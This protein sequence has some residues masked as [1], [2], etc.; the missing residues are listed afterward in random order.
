MYNTLNADQ[1]S[2][3]LFAA[4]AKD[5][6]CNFTHLELLK[7]KQNVPSTVDLYQYFPR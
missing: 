6:L 1:I 4:K 7:W 2:L 3:L 5:T